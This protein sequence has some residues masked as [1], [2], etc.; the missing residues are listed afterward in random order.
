[1]TEPGPPREMRKTFEAELEKLKALFAD[2]K[3]DHE[4]LREDRERRWR[5]EYLLAESQ[6]VLLGD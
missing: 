4:A 2:I 3:D 5:A 1:V 6:K